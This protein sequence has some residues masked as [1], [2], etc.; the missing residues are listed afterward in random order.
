ML[1]NHKSIWNSF[2]EGDN[3]ALSIIYHEHVQLLFRYGKK[4]TNN[5]DLIKDSIQDLFFDLI[6]SRERL[7]KTDNITYY[8]IKSFRR[9]L[10]LNIQKDMKSSDE[11]QFQNPVEDENCDAEDQQKN[12]RVVKAIMHKLSPKQREI[13]TY[14]YILNFS[15]EEI[16]SLMSI[17]YDSARKMVYRALISAREKAT[18]D[19]SLLQ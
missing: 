3:H 10:I 9:K 2:R 18:A 12:N 7:G 5:C 16:C 8:L 6:N 15:Y 13:L 19:N 1:S 14:R 11:I 17:K 4:F